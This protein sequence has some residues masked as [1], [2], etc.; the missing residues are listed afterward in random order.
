MSLLNDMLRDLSHPAKSGVNTSLEADVLVLND[1]EQRELFS[2]SSAA[3]PLSRSLVPSIIVFVL[4]LAG[5]IGARYFFAEP[6]T[7]FPAVPLIDIATTATENKTTTNVTSEAAALTENIST[8]VSNVAEDISI[9]NKAT[10]NEATTNKA[11]TNKAISDVTNE[12]I[13]APELGER[14]A[15]LETAVTTLTTVVAETKL[16]AVK[17]ESLVVDANNNALSEAATGSVSIKEPFVA[18]AF[19]AETTG[20]E[21]V[22]ETPL[23]KNVTEEIVQDKTL[24]API[25]AADASLT[26]SPNAGWQDQQFA[27]Q[28]QKKFRAGQVGLTIIELQDFIASQ[29][30][31]LESTKLL[32]DI[33]LEQ[34]NVSAVQQALAQAEFLPG[35]EK[36]YYAAKIALLTGL[37]TEAIS[38]LEQSLAEAENH[39][40]YRALLAGLY[41]RN[42]MNQEAASHYRRLIHVFGEKPAYWLGFALAQDA[43]N[44][45]QLAIQAYQRVNQYADLQPQVRTY[46]E[47][48]LAALQQ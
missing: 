23:D 16:Q 33:L 11:T 14:L 46:I 44:Q 30:A 25:P 8:S 19:G 17:R 47:Q 43:L 1:A 39:E 36:R 42:G 6:L 10:T 29:A 4:V 37:D 40:N 22:P 9:T 28:A 27:M 45:A 21:P 26:I 35:V 24:A 18:D 13:A 20:A 12:V 38:L 2:Q 41:Q 31:P 15:A 48:R 34:E 3:K 5:F 32:L 7:A